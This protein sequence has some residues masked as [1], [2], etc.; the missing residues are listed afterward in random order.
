MESAQLA[1]SSQSFPIRPSLGHTRPANESG[2]FDPK[3]SSSTSTGNM[4]ANHVRGVGGGATGGSGNGVRRRRHKRLID[5]SRNAR[6]SPPTISEH[7]S[8]YHSHLVND[9]LSLSADATEETMVTSTETLDSSVRVRKMPSTP[10]TTNTISSSLESDPLPQSVVTLTRSFPPPEETPSSQ[11]P[12][13]LKLRNTSRADATD[14]LSSSE[15]IPRRRRRIYGVDG[16]QPKSIRNVP[17]TSVLSPSI[18]GT[19]PKLLPRPRSNSRVLASRPKPKLLKSSTDPSSTAMKE[20]TVVDDVLMDRAFVIRQNLMNF[21]MQELA[22]EAEK[23]ADSGLERFVGSASKFGVQDTPPHRPKFVDDGDF[24][25]PPSRSTDGFR[26]PLRPKK[27][28]VDNLAHPMEYTPSYFSRKKIPVTS[29]RN[30]SEIV[31][32]FSEMHNN[33]RIHLGREGVDVNTLPELQSRQSLIKN[34]SDDTQKEDY[35][36]VISQAPSQAGSNSS[37]SSFAVSSLASLRDIIEYVHRPRSPDDSTIRTS[38][39][40]V[41]QNNTVLPKDL[42]QSGSLWNTSLDRGNF[43][44]DRKKAI[45]TS[46]SHSPTHF[47]PAV[48]SPSYDSDDSSVEFYGRRSPLNLSNQSDPSNV[49]EMNQRRVS[50]LSHSRSNA[51]SSDIRR[52]L[53]EKRKKSASVSF[54]IE[55]ANYHMLLDRMQNNTVST[56]SFDVDQTSCVASLSNVDFGMPSNPTN[57]EKTSSST[58]MANFLHKIQNKFSLKGAD[59]HRS[60]KADDKD[61]KDFVTNFFYTNEDTIILDPG[62]VPTAKQLKLDINPENQRDAYCLPGCGPNDVLSACETVTNYADVI[63]DWFNVKDSHQGKKKS[64]IIDP[65]ESEQAINPN[66]IKGWQQTIDDI[67]GNKRVFSPPKLSVRHIEEYDESTF[68]SPGSVSQ[69]GS[70]SC[71]ELKDPQS[72]CPEIQNN[73]GCSE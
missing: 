11:I 39:S 41:S 38:L 8:S 58:P 19:R 4:E 24:V 55:K 67:N 25:M 51:I 21:E 31:P 59:G 44:A 42:N 53:L 12:P 43:P 50:S 64:S 22:A 6:L 54:E 10:L 34:L 23:A 27:S 56:A 36:D 63:F 52:P 30:F 7:H 65:T 49:S 20:T 33:I 66:W 13:G 46:L 37:F 17:R 29:L 5:K 26:T 45:N 62:G 15:R 72:S 73:I 40:N 32:N 14:S 60:F 28:F 16:D 68:C 71:P 61:N 35:E 69:G 18:N 3:L 9:K 47:K 2:D 57:S 70:L 1:I 48:T